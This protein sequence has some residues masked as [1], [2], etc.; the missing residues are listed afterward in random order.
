MLNGNRRI[1]ILLAVLKQHGMGGPLRD[2]MWN[3]FAPTCRIAGGRRIE[4]IEQGPGDLRAIWVKGMDRPLYVPEEF[5]L[6]CIHQV[7]AEQTY[8][9]NWHY[10]CTPQTLVQAN[11]V[12]LDCGAAEGI[13][14]MLARQKRARCVAFEPHPMYF[15]A[16]QQTFAGDEDVMLVNSALG[17]SPETGFLSKGEIDSKVNDT[18][19]YSIKVETIDAVCDRLKIAPTYLKADI[20]GFEDKM[21]QGAAETISR[22]HPKIAMT[23]YHDE[24]DVTALVATLRRLWPG[25]R[26]GTKG[27]CDR[28]GKPVM[29]HAW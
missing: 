10:Y 23:V 3:L 17:S 20:E 4:R 24:N 22:H 1:Q 29:L 5:S 16:L 8:A 11:D 21:L 26:T 6:H 18:N 7:L 14:T 12:V 13:F 25:Y 28:Y 19:G 9:R 15:R 2:L 27:I